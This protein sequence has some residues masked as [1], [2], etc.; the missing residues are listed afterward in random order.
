MK[1]IIDIIKEHKGDPID[2]QWLNDEKPGICEIPGITLSKRYSLIIPS[3]K[4]S[5]LIKY[6]KYPCGWCNWPYRKLYHR[7]FDG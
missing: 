1:N 5:C 3:R 4:L 7:H 6:W 2:D